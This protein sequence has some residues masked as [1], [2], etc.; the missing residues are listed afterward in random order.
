MKGRGWV[1]DIMG[2]GIWHVVWLETCSYPYTPGKELLGSGPFQT[3]L[4]L[5]GF[6]LRFAFTGLS[7][8]SQP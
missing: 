1:A 5:T 6:V 7:W 4:Y 8:K 2:Q 3:A